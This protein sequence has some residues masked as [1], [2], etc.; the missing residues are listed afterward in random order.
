MIQV[1]KQSVKQ[2]MMFE[3]LGKKH[4]FQDTIN[5]FERKYGMSYADFEKRIET[6]DKEVYEEWDDSID[7]GAAVDM[8]EDVL[9]TIEEIKQ[10]AIEIVE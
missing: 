8:L 7:W 4:R 1:S 3:Y 6:A 10:G 2:W 9:K 5:M